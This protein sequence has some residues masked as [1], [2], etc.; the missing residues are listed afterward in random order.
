MLLVE[1]L[2]KSIAG[3]GLSRHEVCFLETLIKFYYYWIDC[4]SAVFFLLLP[5]VSF[6]PDDDASAGRILPK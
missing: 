4:Q 3:K 2:L 6:L 1:L 5:A